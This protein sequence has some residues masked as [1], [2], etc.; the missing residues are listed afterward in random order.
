VN[1]IYLLLSTFVTQAELRVADQNFPAPWKCWKPRS[2]IQC[3]NTRV[4][5]ETNKGRYQFRQLFWTFFKTICFWMM[6]WC[7]G[8]LFLENY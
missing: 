6:I 5:D 3:W 7:T 2:P 8:L 1:V 4:T